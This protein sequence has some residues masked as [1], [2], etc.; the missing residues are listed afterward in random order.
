M[1][2]GIDPSS[3]R[4]VQ[5]SF[6]HH[7]D[8]A[9]AQSRQQELVEL[10]GAR[11]A[12]APPES[13][14]MTVQELLDAFLAA[15]HRWSATTWRSHRGQ[16]ALLRADRIRRARLDRMS[17][18][19]VERAIE[20]WAREGVTASN[21][22]G[23]FATLHAAISWA[24]KNRLLIDDPLA[25]VRGPR[26]PLPR[27]HLRPG[28]VRRL[29]LTA[30]ERVEKADARLVEQP[31][32]HDRALAAFRAEQDALLVRLAADSAARRG[33][34]VAFTLGD[35]AGR[36]LTIERASQDGVIGPVKN[37]LRASMTLGTDTAAYW[38]GHVARWSGES[39]ATAWLFSA[40]P[41]RE[42][43]LLPNGLGQRFEKLARAAGLPEA[44]L[45]RLRHTV[46]TY[47][48]SQGKILQ[49][50]KRLRHSDVA[51][52]LREYA[53]AI[54]LD[55]HDTADTLATLYGV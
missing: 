39:D 15:P 42:K 55:D 23:R 21:L 6:T 4:S 33:E 3:G 7:G 5:R 27:L 30:D 2:T 9:S 48:V 35:L 53:H 38:H 12:Q 26:R 10:H 54:P 32:R 29:I 13:A 37:H 20:R 25:G 11:V 8:A 44:T 49:A 18:M 50:S 31:F 28:E 43:P 19:T 34:L 16:A 45:H 41:D 51:T 52:T 46:G 17:A 14:A 40:T 36:T 22:C 1:S 24:V 47:L